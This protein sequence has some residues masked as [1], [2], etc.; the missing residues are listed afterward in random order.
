MEPTAIEAAA[1]SSNFFVEALQSKEPAIYAIFLIGILTIGLILERF[2]AL[3]RYS[4]EKTEFN[5]HIFG[6]VLRGDIRGAITFCDSKPAP[7]TNTVK[8]GLIQV[9]NHRPDEE[10]QVAMDASVLR[11]TPKVEGWVS[12][13]AVFGNL[14]TLAGLVGTIMG[15]ITSF[16]GVSKM[17][18]AQK[19]TE[20]SKGISQALHSTALGLIVA[21]VAI[22]AYG[23]FQVRIGRLINDMVESSMRLMNVVVAN[24]EKMKE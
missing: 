1:A 17:D 19:A 11:E 7:L 4:I 10:V 6:A 22:L 3:S 12:F 23:Y 18:G 16:H 5:D 13:L 8:E 14:S 9:L 21:L 15:M 20:L 24:R 2:M